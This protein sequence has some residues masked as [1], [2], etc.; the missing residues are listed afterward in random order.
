MLLKTVLEKEGSIS[1]LLLEDLIMELLIFQ[2][3]KKME[4]CFAE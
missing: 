3:V 1:C 4:A 2:D